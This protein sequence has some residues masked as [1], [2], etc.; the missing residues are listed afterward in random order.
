MTEDHRVVNASFYEEH[1][2]DA[3]YT[4]HKLGL[5]VVAEVELSE[6]DYSFDIAMV[7]WHVLTDSFY[8][9]RDSGCSCPSPFETFDSLDKLNGPL[10]RHEA[11]KWLKG[12]VN[13]TDDPETWKY[14]DDPA[15]VVAGIEKVM[16]FRQ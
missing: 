6:P 3:Y 12:F 5:E 15:K 2:G 4:P 8:V 10:S 13:E 7:W 11:A 16:N 1:Y 14:A 9:A